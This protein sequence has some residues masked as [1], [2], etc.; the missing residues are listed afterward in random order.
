ML[1]PH[2]GLLKNKTAIIPQPGNHSR[3]E[4]KRTEREEKGMAV[5]HARPGMS[6]SPSIS[7]YVCHVVASKI[8]H[9]AFTYA[10]IPVHIYIYI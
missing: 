7:V 5:V 2:H 10:L 8:H 9:Y 6:L 4:K 3:R 1:Q